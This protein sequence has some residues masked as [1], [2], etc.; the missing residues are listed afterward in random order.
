MPRV[1]LWLIVALA[2]LLTPG[3]SRGGDEDPTLKG[4]KLSEWLELLHGD[5]DA[6]S[7]NMI[8]LCVGGSAYQPVA[9]MQYRYRRAALIAVE[10][11]GPA[12][13]RK[14]I[15]AVAMALR[16]DP[17]ARVREG[18]AQALGRLSIKAKKQNFRFTDAREALVT[19]LRT[20]RTGPVRQAAAM[21]LGTVDPD[22]PRQIFLVIDP[23][24]LTGFLAAALKDPHIGTSNAAAETLRKIGKG[25]YEVVPDML[26]VVKNSKADSLTRIPLIH[27]L[28]KIG[29]PDA[30]AAVPILKEALTDAQAPLDVRRAAA[31]NAASFGREG[32]D[33]IP[34][35]ANLLTDAASPVELRRAAVYG[36]DEFGSDTRTS[37]PAV[38]K[39]VGDP[40]KFVRCLAM[41]ALGQMGRDL[42]DEAPSV[43]KLLLKTLED[44]VIEVRVAALETFGNLGQ[45]ALGADAKAVVDRVTDLT[46]N[47]RKE[48]REAAENALKKLKGM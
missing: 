15:P 18:A 42:G 40:D 2:A 30:N 3:P 29:S 7:L 10:V 1:L 28:G 12:K 5:G 31:E 20:D 41:H 27:C 14:V 36:L 19:A 43:V 4:R 22:S 23:T 44:P 21:A 9:D 45:E 39:A 16:N 24:G 13:S 26:E 47:S 25:A 34:V 32:F 48:V 33:L 17:D 8:L 35:L 46:R 37:L 6:G 11:I 38:K